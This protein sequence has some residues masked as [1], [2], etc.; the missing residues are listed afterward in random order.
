MESD[1]DSEFEGFLPE[2][3]L[4]VDIDISN[5]VGSDFSD[6]SSG[7]DEDLDLTTADENQHGGPSCSNEFIWQ[8]TLN[9]VT[10]PSFLGPEPGPTDILEEGK[11]E[12]D[13]FS[14]F[15]G[16]NLYTLIAEETNRYHDAKYQNGE[17]NWSNVTPEG[18]R[19]F[20]ALRVFMS[21]STQPRTNMY[22]SRDY[23]FG[24]YK[25]ADIMTR[26]RFDKISE[27][28][29]TNDNSTN[30][31]RGEINHDKLHHVR[32]ILDHVLDNCSKRYNP[33]QNTS[34]DEA[35]VAF[36]GRIGFKQYMPAKPVKYGIKVWVRADPNN[37]FV[38]E[39]QVYTG[40]ENMTAE[41]GLTS[42]VVLDLTRKC[43][44]QNMIVNVDNF[45][46][47]ANLFRELE[48]VG[49][50]ARGTCR[51]NRKNWPKNLKPKDEDVKKWPSGE[52]KIMQASNLTAGMWKDKRIVNFMSTADSPLST[53]E[54]QRKQK[55]GT[56]K[57]VKC[58]VTIKEYNSNMAGVDRSDQLRMEYPT[59]RMSK[60]WWL[61]LFY[62]LFDLSISNA[63]VLYKESKKHVKKTKNG[64]IIPT[65]LLEFKMNLFKKMIGNARNGRK[66]KRVES[67]EDI[68]TAPGGHYPMRTAKRARCR[69]CSKSKKRAETNL[70]C[71]NCLVYLC[72]TCFRAY[73]ES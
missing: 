68:P 17:K 64:K 25:I 57:T 73:H 59:Y 58:P 24:N 27:N 6:I 18:I 11:N 35:M 4:D 54:V 40:K 9:P 43:Q 21:I 55:D 26:D 22:W 47:S 48:N 19:D 71:D 20:L 12:F 31:A 14:L 45:Y 51:T 50:F 32:P 1:T 72:A 67:G 37:G 66:R 5:A 39:F 42:R 29:H 62:F 70:Q 33:H 61:Y 10:S 65:S 15:F 36:R 7:E 56:V 52:Y 41:I 13:F 34:I 49:I 44:F 63:F 23:Y 30:P 46:T 2:D 28:F 38:N 60:K 8:T 16:L 69:Q 3:I 53:V